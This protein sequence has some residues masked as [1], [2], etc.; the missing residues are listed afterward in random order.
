MGFTVVRFNPLDENHKTGRY[1][2]LV[3]SDR[4]AFR[5]TPSNLPD[6]SFEGTIIRQIQM[7]V[8]RYATII[9]AVGSSLWWLVNSSLFDPILPLTIEDERR[10]RPIGKEEGGRTLRRAVSGNATRLQ[11]KEDDEKDRVEYTNSYEATLTGAGRIQINYWVLKSKPTETGKEKPIET[12]VESAN[13]IYVTLYGADPR[14]IEP[15]AR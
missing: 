8:H 14:S 3:R 13:P 4:N 11:G 7:D 9:T 5:E 15:T 1:E 10:D 2:Y 6:P 12:Y